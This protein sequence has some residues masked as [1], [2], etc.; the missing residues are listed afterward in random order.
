[1]NRNEAEIK[2]EKLVTVLL[3]FFAREGVTFSEAY[4]NSLKERTIA[5][6]LR[7]PVDYNTHRE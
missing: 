2:A 7:E 3:D 4:R 5:D 1:M 6:L